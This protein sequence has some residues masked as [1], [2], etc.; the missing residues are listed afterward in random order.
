MRLLAT[1]LVFCIGLSALPAAY[2]Q[3]QASPEAKAVANPRLKRMAAGSYHTCALTETNRVKCWGDN[4]RGQLGDGTQTDRLTAG[5]VLSL[6]GGLKSV[7]AGSDHTCVL[8]SNG[9]IKCWGRG[10]VGALGDGLALDRYTPA[11][12]LGLS[13]GAIAVTAGGDHTCAITKSGGVK[14]WGW[15]ATGQLGDGTKTLRLAPVSV[16]GLSA[17]VI[18]ISAGG[19]YTCAVEDT[20]RVKCWGGNINRQLGDGTTDERLKPVAVVGLRGAAAVSASPISDHTCALTTGGAAICWGKN[21]SGQLGDG[22]ADE[23]LQPV[24]VVGLTRGVRAIAA[25]NQF[26]CALL[27]SGSVQCW[28]A[29]LAA[30][31]LGNDGLQQIYYTPVFVSNF[32]GTS[33]SSG[34][35]HSCAHVTS[36]AAACWG[37]NADGQ[38]GNGDTLLR[39]VPARVKRF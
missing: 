26:T 20:G 38:L 23:R 22:T 13:S 5:P 12:V 16:K 6:G 1:T 10:I 34:M 39:K 14:C 25:A 24:A 9:G 30:A 17:K 4:T 33:I 19:D 3:D 36:G 27:G 35:Y 37:T 8:T 15:N 7:A 28:G 29:N 11:F 31:T 32:N 18:A 21:N 2:A